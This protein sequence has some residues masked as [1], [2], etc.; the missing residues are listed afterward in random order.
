MI[1]KQTVL[2]KLLRLYIANINLYEE[3]I[4]NEFNV[5][6]GNYSNKRGSNQMGTFK[7]LDGNYFYFH[8]IGCAIR[9]GDPKKLEDEKTIVDWDYHENGLDYFREDFLYY[10]IEE[11]YSQLFKTFGERAGLED[12]VEKL[13]QEKILERPDPGKKGILHIME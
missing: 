10:F 12:L 1:N 3:L 6:Q 4:K 5:G 13:I 8:G 11:N 7:E 2:L 9:N